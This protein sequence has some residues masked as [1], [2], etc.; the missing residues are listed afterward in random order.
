MDTVVQSHLMSTNMD[1]RCWACSEDVCRTALT[2]I[3]PQMLFSYV[4]MFIAPVIACY[5]AHRAEH[6]IAYY[7]YCCT[8][9]TD[10]KKIIFSIVLQW[11]D[12]LLFTCQPAHGAI[13][14]IL[15]AHNHSVIL[16][17]SDHNYGFVS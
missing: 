10:C 3:R 12:Y 1:I 9:S 11:S 8:Q 4:C 7:C 15:M 13:D 16:I 14:K 5:F 2:L 17:I 6:K